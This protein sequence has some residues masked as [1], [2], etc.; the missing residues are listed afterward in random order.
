MSLTP[1]KKLHCLLPTEK[2]TL[3]QKGESMR[4]K[5]CS[6]MISMLLLSCSH[7][8]KTEIQRNYNGHPVI[9]IWDYGKNGCTETYEFLPN[10]IRNVT[11]NQE[12]V[13]ASYTIT[14]TR[15]ERGFYKLT[16]KVLEDNGKADCSGST[17]D[18]TGDIVELY[19]AFNPR[20]DQLIFCF[21]ESFD[22]CF[23]PFKKR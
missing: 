23:G 22:K 14:E 17:S 7:A 9:G 2:A 12:V 10:G 13:K 18:M 20:K 11:S 6:L 3:S 4:I 16:D 8:I 15:S 1:I 5:I 21:E 19:V